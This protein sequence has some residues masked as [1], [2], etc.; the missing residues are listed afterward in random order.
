[1][2]KKCGLYA[3]AS[4]GILIG[5]LTPDTKAQEEP[6]SY[7]EQNRQAM[8]TCWRFMQ[9]WLQHTDPKTGLIPRNLKR[10]FYWNAKDAAADNYPFM[11]LT[12]FFTDQQQFTGPMRTM[13]ETEQ[14]LCN[15]VGR[16]PDDYLFSTQSFRTQQPELDALIFGASEY[17]KDGLLP[18][19]EWLG[20]DSPWATRMLGLLEDIWKHAH[21]KTET[22]L[23]PST[24]HE[25]AG[26]MMQSLSRMYWMTGEDAFKERAFQLA[27]YYFE[28]H[29][30]TQ[31]DHLSLDDHGCEVISGLSEAYYLA[32]QKAPKKHALWRPAM[33]AMLDCILEVG[34]DSKGLMYMSVDPKRGKIKKRERTDNWG[35]NYNAFALVGKLDNIPRYIDAI[36]HVLDNLM[37]SKDYP[38]EN[39]SADGFA[40]ALEGCLNLINRYPSEQATAWADYTAQRLINVQ[41]DSGIFEG[42]HGDGNGARTLIMYALWKSQGTYVQ[43]WR[44]DIGIGANWD[45]RTQTLTITVQTQWPYTGKL[46][47]DRARHQRYLHLPEDYP[48]INQFPEWFTLTPSTTYQI[49]MGDDNVKTITTKELEN[50]LPIVIPEDNSLQL[51]ITPHID[52]SR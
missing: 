27:A 35:Y 47:F 28:H 33:H 41:R 6:L 7:T 49:R 8:L 39:N 12:S 17:V 10:D 1:M 14:R 9:G 22:G 38:W 42:W 20:P 23:V 16:L 51:I 37:R 26:E 11:V 32:A 31:T 25:V 18:L 15:R 3:L 40:D 19:T 5:I 34:I 36:Q 4:L 24:S 50:G 21:I 48:R 45:E 2:A 46:H 44:A 52:S 43:P 30:P 29:L 13:L